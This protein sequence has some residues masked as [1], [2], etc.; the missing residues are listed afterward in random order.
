MIEAENY[1]KDPKNET[2]ILL[3]A[4]EVLAVRFACGEISP[5]EYQKRLEELKSS[6]GTTKNN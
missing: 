4:E 6:E 5:E 3:N 2:N 1:R